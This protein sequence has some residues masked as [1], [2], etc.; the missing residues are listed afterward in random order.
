M[1]IN[2]NNFS[3]NRY[4]PIHCGCSSR[5]YYFQFN[6]NNVINVI[7]CLLGP[8]GSYLAVRWDVRTLSFIAGFLAASGFIIS[9]FLPNV[10][11]LYITFGIMIG[12]NSVNHNTRIAH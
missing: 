5:P 11:Y 6:N 8:I 12:E 4:I 3:H 2:G 9:M 7:R 1:G 10:L